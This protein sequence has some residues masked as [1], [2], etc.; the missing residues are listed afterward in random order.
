MSE[1][2]AEPVPVRPRLLVL[3]SIPMELRRVLEPEYELAYRSSLVAGPAPGFQVAVTTSM[4]GADAALMN[5]MP[6]LKLIACNGT[7]ME[8]IDLHEARRLGI[9]VCNT[10]DAV[11]E[12]TADFAVGLTYAVLRRIVEADQFVRA[13]SWGPGKMTPS[14]RVFDKRLGVVGLGKI[15]AA[16]ARRGASLGMRVAYTA[17]R[18][19][20]EV[21]YAYLP[22]VDE[23]A[24]CVDV[25]ILACPGGEATRHLVNGKTLAA[26]GSGGILINISRG[27][28]LDEEALI[29]ALG[30]GVIAG[31]GLDVF[32]REPNLDERLLSFK[33][34]VLSPH[35]ASTTFETRAAIAADLLQNIRSFF[36]GGP[37][38]NSALHMSP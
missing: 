31:A 7:G 34:V 38:R 35:Y 6:D 19:K 25:L 37:V 20:P 1:A 4:D 22:N 21:D 28:V 30:K 9:A 16:I 3:G 29:E 2:R 32:A 5:S 33:N 8:K 15:G 13:G 27:S 36:S 24:L 17:T 11:T 26:L 12:D 18:R 23:L 10:P 14:R